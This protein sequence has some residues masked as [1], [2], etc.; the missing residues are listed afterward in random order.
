[1]SVLSLAALLTKQGKLLKA[2]QCGNSSLSHLTP[3]LARMYQ[4]NL[5]FFHVG[6]LS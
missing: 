5:A 6:R 2:E 4:D 1:M 3:D